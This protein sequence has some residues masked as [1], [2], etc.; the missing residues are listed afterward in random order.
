MQNTVFVEYENLKL[1]ATKSSIR[2]L[3]AAERTQCV[4]CL[5]CMYENL[6]LECSTHIKSRCGG[7]CL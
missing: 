6:S 2:V 4:K 5:L 3:S 1:Q 7:M